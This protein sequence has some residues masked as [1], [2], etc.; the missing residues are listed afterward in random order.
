MPVRHP[1]GNVNKVLPYSRYV[2][3]EMLEMQR[4]S[5]I[6]QSFMWAVQ[7]SVHAPYLFTNVAILI[8]LENL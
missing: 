6:R 2:D 7:S 1:S 5:G 8:T 4:V 3:P